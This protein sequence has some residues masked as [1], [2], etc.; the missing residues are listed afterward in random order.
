M[1]GDHRGPGAGLAAVHDRYFTDTAPASSAF[2]VTRLSSDD[3]LLEI[4]A[5]A[6]LPT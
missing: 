5:I 6:A 4:E 1:G 3:L 2:Q